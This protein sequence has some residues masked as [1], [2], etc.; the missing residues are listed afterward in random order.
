VT[1][2][3]SPFDG[4]HT[5]ELTFMPPTSS[6]PTLPVVGIY[7]PMVSD[8]SGNPKGF[9]SISVY[10]TD[11]TQ[12]AA[13]FIAQ[14]SV[15]NTSYST[16][17]TP[18]R[19]VDAA[20]DSM[21]V[22]AP[23][24]GTLV[25]STPI[26]FGENATA[27]GL[28]PGTVYY[29]ASVPTANADNTTYTFQISEQWLQPLSAGN[30]PI[31]GPGG[32]PGPIVD[33]TSPVGA[34]ALTYGMVKPVTQLGSSQLAANQLERNADGSLTMWFGPTRPAGAPASNWIPT[35]STAYYSTLYPNTDVSTAFQ[36]TLRMYYPTPGNE[37]PSILPC[38]QACARLL[39]ESYIPPAVQLGL[40][41]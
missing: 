35:P 27:Y 12:G 41:G 18:V 40:S 28:T 14:T 25:A 33:L 9:W 39:H 13:P 37:P 11:P 10:A 38:T 2:N 4:N 24:W 31:Q 32:E 36:L 1:G 22:S 23:N 8:S 34:G 30:V 20:A 19:S 15:L 3:P 21:T 26:L 17:D 5:Y 16:A 29:V 6:N 7:P